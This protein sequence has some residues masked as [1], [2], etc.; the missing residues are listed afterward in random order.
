MKEASGGGLRRKE[1][2]WLSPLM[3]ANN[4]EVV[5][6]LRLIKIYQ[7]VDLIDKLR[8]SLFVRIFSWSL[9]DLAVKFFTLN[10]VSLY[11]VRWLTITKGAP[12]ILYSFVFGLSIL[13]IAV[14][15]PLLGYFSDMT[16]R[17]H[18]LLIQFTI[19]GI[20]FTSLL[21]VTDNI[22]FA[23]IFFICANFSVQI[24]V[25]FYNA[26]IVGIAPRE[27]M[28]F[29][30]GAGKMIGYIGSILALYLIRPIVD[31]GGYRAS[32]L[33]SAGLFLL[34]SLPCMLFIRDKGGGGRQSLLKFIS[35]GEIKKNLL[36]LKNSLQ[37][38]AAS[39]AIANFFKASFFVL[40][41]LNAI[42]VFMSVYLT[43]VYGLSEG[44]IIQFLLIGALFAIMGSL[45]FGFLSDKIGPKLSLYAVFGLWQA[46]L[47]MASLIP[48]DNL[49]HL[50]AIVLGVAFG[51][52]WTVSRAMG[53]KLVPE[54]RVGEFFGVFAFIGYVSGMLGPLLWGIL[55]FLLSGLGVIRYRIIVLL[56][57]IFWIIGLF[58]LRRIPEKET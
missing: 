2:R 48:A 18:A 38:F 28:G 57:N 21:A 51:S 24:A 15:S 3:A 1:N 37:S 46:G 52:V 29:V 4:N 34:F 13:F 25:I 10:I 11:F 55:A 39:Y 44:R 17:K 19:S 31:T 41:P 6:S 9:Y 23:I 50:T 35:F 42:I 16:R 8:K 32:F 45:L 14:F 43:K 5:L 58:Y 22:F 26:L 40:I 33:P 30:S 49:V 36:S 12:D 53:V 27:K 56:F 47:I 54:E 20:I 7:A